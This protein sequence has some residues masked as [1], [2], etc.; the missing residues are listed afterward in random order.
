[1]KIFALDIELYGF[2]T[3]SGL[4]GPRDYRDMPHYFKSGLYD[5][6]PELLEKKLK[7]AKLVIG[8]VKN[9]TARFFEAY[10]PAPIGCIFHDLDFYSS[11]IDALSLF[12]ADSS[13]F[14]PRLFMYFDD[15]FGNDVWLC[16][17]YTG[18][19]L[20]IAEFNQSH[21]LKKICSQYNLPLQHPDSWWPSHVW[22]YHDFEHPKYNEFIA[23]KEQVIRQ[24][25]IKLR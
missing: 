1:M 21:R 11:T 16:N 15:V 22:I 19:R 2:D 14:L 6:D 7:R 12:D 9:T 24:S 8:D 17:D 13:R 4:P 25:G 3:G 23:D 18:E 10:N 20:A 5:M